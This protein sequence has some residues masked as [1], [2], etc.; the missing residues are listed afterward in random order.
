MNRTK[1]ALLASLIASAVLTP[2]AANAAPADD[3][4]IKALEESFAAAVRA[5]DVNAIMKAYAPNV[6]VFDVT[7]PRQY[8]GAAAYRED[9]KGFVAGYP[10]PIKFE[11]SDLVV[12]T[13][14]SFGYSHSIQHVTGT[15]AKGG[16]ADI[17]V[18]V[19]D[20]YRKVRGAWLIVHEHV[21]VPVDLNTGK[22]DVTSK[23]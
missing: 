9:W 12:S 19:T 1:Q 17:T 8:A 18:R 11:I 13:E 14:G 22:A 5:K 15:D 16:A 20:V 7:P 21:S 6:L 4:Q 3:A 10:G 23:P 2:F